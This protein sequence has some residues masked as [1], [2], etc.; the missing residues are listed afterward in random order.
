MI[1]NS[2]EINENEN[3]KSNYFF[4]DR[5]YVIKY[6]EAIKTYFNKHFFEN[7]KKNPSH[8]DNAL[9][10]FN[11]LVA[12]LLYCNHKN[13]GLIFPDKND[14]DYFCKIKR[15]NQN[16]ITSSKIICKFKQNLIDND[17]I[18]IK[19][20]GI[21]KKFSNSYSLTKYGISTFKKPNNTTVE[22]PSN[23]DTEKCKT[24]YIQLKNAKKKQIDYTDNN[25]TDKLRYVAEKYNN[26]INKFII[27]DNNGFLETELF[28]I[29]RDNFNDYGRWFYRGAP[30]PQQLNSAQRSQIRIMNEL[31][32]EYDYSC[33]HPNLLYNEI[34]S[35]L[36]KDAYDI[37]GYNRKDVKK[38]L[39]IILNCKS[40]R[41]AVLAIKNNISG[42]IDVSD[43]IDKLDMYHKPISHFFYTEVAKRLQNIDAQMMLYTIMIFIAK[44]IPILC[45][46]DSIL[47]PSSISPAFV[48]EV[49]IKAYNFRIKDWLDNKPVKVRFT[50][51]IDMKAFNN[52]TKYIM[53]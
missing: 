13:K 32:H 46:H 23:Q 43:L 34:G 26:F 51:N 14:G 9:K 30:N 38:V 41:Q 52:S 5:L 45:I 47:V 17:L 25:L 18:K 40:K 37:N 16:E 50:P 12:N 24:D 19:N 7:Y 28:K 36:N 11:C 33:L 48:E 21:Y 8:K 2:F 15:Y 53:Q 3:M 6:K 29:H 20:K 4:S 22:Q 27:Y 35:E 1:E 44:Q 10:H 42:I 39:N 49:M 31:C